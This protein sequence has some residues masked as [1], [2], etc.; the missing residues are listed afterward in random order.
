MLIAPKRMTTPKR[1]ISPRRLADTVDI[2]ELR[3]DLA[4]K[5]VER[6]KRL[7]SLE[8]QGKMALVEA[9]TLFVEREIRKLK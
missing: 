2:T 6:N 3:D 9:A 1:G 8:L 4:E 7:K 5:I